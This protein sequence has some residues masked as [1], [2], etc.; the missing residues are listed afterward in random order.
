[1]EKIK[2]KGVYGVFYSMEEFRKLQEK[3]IEQNDLIDM[4]SQDVLNN[5]W[6]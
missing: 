4:I 3:I 1:M 2:H 6:I 5:E